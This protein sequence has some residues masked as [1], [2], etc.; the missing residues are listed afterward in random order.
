[1]ETL[2]HIAFG[3]GD[4]VMIRGAGDA[5]DGK[6]G[7]IGGIAL[8]EAPVYHY[9]VLLDEPMDAPAAYPGKQWPSIMMA[10]TSLVPAPPAAPVP[11]T[12]KI[13]AMLSWLREHYIVDLRS[14][15]RG[16][17]QL[18]LAERSHAGSYGDPHVLAADMPQYTYDGDLGAAVAR[19]ANAYGFNGTRDTEAH[20]VYEGK[21][22]CPADDGPCER[23][24]SSGECTRLTNGDPH[25]RAMF[26]A[27]LFVQRSGLASMATQNPTRYKALVQQIATLISDA[28]ISVAGTPTC[29][30]G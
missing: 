30:C 29:K 3:V 6:L 11:H 27:A 25:Q 21:R 8:A 12:Y 13:A 18:G 16:E 15:S 5:V 1:M 24:C 17:W 10:G 19:M 2:N 22:Q 20:N 23:G 28:R 7:E 9:I 14:Q 4:R 26:D